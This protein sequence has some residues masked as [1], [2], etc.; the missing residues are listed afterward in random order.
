MIWTYIKQSNI[1][2]LL[3]V[4][5]FLQ[6]NSVVSLN[7]HVTYAAQYTIPISIQVTDQTVESGDIVSLINNEYILSSTP[8]DKYLQGVIITNPVI[9]ITTLKIDNP[10]YLVNAGQARVKVTN[11]AGDIHQGDVITSSDIAGV[12]QL[13]TK[14]GY[15]LGTALEDFQPTTND[16]IGTV[17]INIHPQSFL[18]PNTLETTQSVVTKLYEL[19]KYFYFLILGFM[20]LILLITVVSFFKKE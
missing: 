14:S 5:I 6:R 10:V 17:S 13:A 15:I 11:Q 2:S 20:M 16:V 4:S 8:Y 9:S 3:L 18:Q 7:Y 12:G 19:P 1:I